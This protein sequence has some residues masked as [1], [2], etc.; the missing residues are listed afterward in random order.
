MRTVYRVHGG[1]VDVAGDA[2]LRGSYADGAD[3]HLL[4]FRVR[5]CVRIGLRSSQSN[6]PTQQ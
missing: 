3:E 5:P 1:E 4:V 2:Q 6:K